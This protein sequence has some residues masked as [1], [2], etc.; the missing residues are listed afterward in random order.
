MNKNKREQIF[1]WLED[2][3][4]SF[5]LL[6]E[7]HST[8]QNEHFWKSGWKG[9]IFFSGNKSNS[10]GVCILVKENE[11]YEFIKHHDIL[12]G[13]IQALEI[14]INEKHVVIINV[15]GPNKDEVSFF[16]KLEVFIRENEDKGIINGG[17]FNTTLNNKIDKKMVEQILIRN[18]V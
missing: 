15:Y 14:K 17:D 10:E 13:R 12:E 18:V 8:K 9:E 4:F 16:D 6:Q 1:K 3:N 5:S 2:K 7:T 11:N